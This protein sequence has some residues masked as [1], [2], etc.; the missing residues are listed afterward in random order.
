MLD[1]GVAAEITIALED[2]IE[3]VSGAIE[4]GFVNSGTAAPIPEPSASLVFASGLLV[5]SVKFGRG[6]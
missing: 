4:D 2:G 3:I 6:R 5:A 1:E